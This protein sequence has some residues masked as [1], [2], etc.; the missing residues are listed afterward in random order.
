ME[1]LLVCLTALVASGLTLFSGFGLGT[2]LLPAFALFFPVEAAVVMTALVHFANNL[3][4]LGLFWRRWNMSIV[5]RFGLPALLMALLGS[6][7][8]YWLADQETLFQYVLGGREFF[9]VPSK[10][11]IGSLMI[12]FSFLESTALAERLSLEARFLPLG[13]ILSGF[14]GGLSGHQGAFRSL[15]LLQCGLSKE[16]FIATGILIACFVDLSRLSVYASRFGTLGQVGNG[17]LLVAAV[18]SAFLGAFLG[19]RFIKKVNMQFIRRLVSGL[20]LLIGTG[21]AL[22]MI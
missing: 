5:F 2:L 10:L 3:F 6:Q 21:L 1:Y 19:R 22:G 4:K 12:V 9:I 15:F 13:G 11:V 17:A 18:M 8:L 20:L 14:F 16:Q 7:A